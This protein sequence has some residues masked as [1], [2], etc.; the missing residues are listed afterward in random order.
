VYAEVVFLVRSY[1]YRE[2]SRRIAEKLEL[3]TAFNGRSPERSGLRA[4]AYK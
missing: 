1:L 3:L 4:L 2:C